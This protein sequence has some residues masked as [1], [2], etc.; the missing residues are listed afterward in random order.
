[1]LSECR[2]LSE[3]IIDQGWDIRDVVDYFSSKIMDRYKAGHPYGVLIF[4]EGIVDVIPEFR[5]YLNGDLH[6]LNDLLGSYGIQKLPLPNVTEDSHGNKNL[7]LVRVEDML[8]ELI[9]AHIAQQEDIDSLQFIH[10]FFG[11]SGRSAVPTSFD[12]S[13]SKLLGKTALELI[14]SD[15]T[16]VLA[17]V[18]VING[19]VMQSGIALH[20]MMSFDST[21]ID[22]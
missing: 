20:A 19:T 6:P 22:Q 10:H 15:V 13:L 9:Y 5:S 21:K 1:M 4:P 14:V 12:Q 2:V 11:Y 18:G 17:G 3:E 8:V 7:S 16:G